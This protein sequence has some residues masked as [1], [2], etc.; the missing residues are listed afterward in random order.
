MF[1][2]WLLHIDGDELFY[3]KDCNAAAHFGKLS[4]IGAHAFNYVNWEAVP[5]AAEVACP[6]R[7]LTLF[8]RNLQACLY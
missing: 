6:F 7:E 4:E 5:E 3:C 2:A 8:K 1:A